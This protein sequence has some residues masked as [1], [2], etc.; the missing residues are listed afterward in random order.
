HRKL[1]QPSSVIPVLPDSDAPFRQRLCSLEF[2][3]L[4]PSTS[5]DSNHLGTRVTAGCSVSRARRDP[6]PYR[7]PDQPWSA[8]ACHPRSISAP[9]AMPSGTPPPPLLRPRPSVRG[10]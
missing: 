6:E 8:A 7:T 10:R 1:T 5:R 3:L 2:P 4:G 9:R